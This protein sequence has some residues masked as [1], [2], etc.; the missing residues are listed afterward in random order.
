MFREHG[1]VDAEVTGRLAG[2]ST[3]SGSSK[4]LGGRRET[5]RLHQGVDGLFRNVCAVDH[6]DVGSGHRC[7]AAVIVETIGVL[8]IVIGGHAVLEGR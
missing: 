7:V 1:E 3:G 8:I 6:R 5:L 4:R 2:P